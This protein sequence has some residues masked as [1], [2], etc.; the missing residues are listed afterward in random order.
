ML[1]HAGEH[2]LIPFSSMIFSKVF[3]V[4]LFLVCSLLCVFFQVNIDHFAEYNLCKFVADYM[5][6]SLSSGKFNNACLLCILVIFLCPSCF[7]NLFS[8]FLLVLLTS[9]FDY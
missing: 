1:S 5:H 8:I 2:Y 7:D 4:S 3:C 6:E 9:F